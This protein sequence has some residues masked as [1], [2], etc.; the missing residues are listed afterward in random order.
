MHS[1]AYNS[2]VSP[3][4]LF[5]RVINI[6]YIVNSRHL[7]SIASI[8][9]RSETRASQFDSDIHSTNLSTEVCS[10]VE[11]SSVLVAVSDA[12]E[13][14]T[15]KTRPT[16]CVSQVCGSL[17]TNKLTCQWN[18]EY[19]AT[20]NGLYNVREQKIF[21]YISWI[22]KKN[23]DTY[24]DESSRKQEYF[25]VYARMNQL[26]VYTCSNPNILFDIFLQ[27][28]VVRVSLKIVLS[29]CFIQFCCWWS[30]LHAMMHIEH[31]YG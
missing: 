15:H 20:K 3:C 6:I 8:G 31:F 5:V 30:T 18:S 26:Y 9:N 16:W 29:N 22:K 17:Q 1:S 25:S 13:A 28:F 24:K 2:N 27:A 14:W 7:A 4:V 11:F 19:T 23:N 12:C 21:V 10:Y